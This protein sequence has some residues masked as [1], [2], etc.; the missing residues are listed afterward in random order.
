MTIDQQGQVIIMVV[1]ALTY[2][3]LTTLE[4]TGSMEEE[5][6]GAEEEDFQEE[7]VMAE[8]VEDKVDLQHEEEVTMEAEEAVEDIEH[9]DTVLFC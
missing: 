6:Q 8:E 5:I 3:N 9:F 4:T 7:E 1:E 2:Q